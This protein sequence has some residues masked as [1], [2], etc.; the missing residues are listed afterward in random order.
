M[1]KPE[2]IELVAL[3]PELD[4]L[5]IK[6]L[7]GLSAEDWDKQ[8][9]V[10]KWKV[11]DVAVHLLDGNLRTLSMLRDGFYGENPEKINSYEDLTSFL[12][13]LN[14][15]WT[16]A[17]KRLSPKVIIDLL[18]T[19][20]KEYCDFLAT[21]NPEDKAQFSVAWAGENESKNWFHIAREYTEKWHH[22]QQIRLAVGDDQELLK[23][24]WFLPYLDTSMRALPYHY[25]N[26]EGKDKD[27]VK[28]TFLGEREKSWFLHYD[29]GW[30]LFAFTD[31][32]PHTEVKISDDFAWKIFTKGIDQEKAIANSEITGDKRLGE[33]I[34]SMVAVMA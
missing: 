24:K 31:R 32:I 27:L 10:P 17:T 11:K 12:N 22:Q 30:D 21:L 13:G 2:R 6:L 28:F 18:K 20:G 33:K 34:F 1:K 14:A 3:M 19:S 15:D 7:E 23:E 29:N 5:L 26:V 25:R 4:K 8:T 16:K 9:I